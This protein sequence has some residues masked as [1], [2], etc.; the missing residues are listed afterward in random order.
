M[1]SSDAAFR[2][3]NTGSIPISGIMTDDPIKHHYILVA[4]PCLNEEVSIGSIVL[5][6]LQYANEVLVIDDG[7]SDKTAV[8]AK[9]AGAEVIK[10]EKNMGKGAGIKDA[11]DYAKDVNA[12][13][14]ILIDGDGQHNPDEIPQLIKPIIDGGVDIVNGSRF[15][16][17]NGFHIPAYSRVG[18]EVLTMVTNS[19]TNAPSRILRMVSALSQRTLSQALASTKKAWGSKAKC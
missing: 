1:A 9:L 3:D 16:I 5:R 13:I 4:V 15:L 10:H 19:S 2:K 6:S 11:F 17:K 12:D 8:I 7:S 14:L 18:Q